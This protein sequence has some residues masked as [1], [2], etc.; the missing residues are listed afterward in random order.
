MPRLPAS[1][2]LGSLFLVSLF[3]CTSGDDA[4]TN[5]DDIKKRVNPS[6]GTAAFELKKPSWYTDDFQSVFQFH[7]V[8]A[9]YGRRYERAGGEFPLRSG[10]LYAPGYYGFGMS[11]GSMSMNV[12][13]EIGFISIY[14]PAGIVLKYERP[15]TAG[16]NQIVGKRAGSG[17]DA[18]RMV[19]NE[20][21]SRPQG[22]SVAML[23]GRYEIET[24]ANEKTTYDI[25]E[26][27]KKDILL[28][29]ASVQLK[30]EAIDAEFPGTTTCLSIDARGDNRTI[31]VTRTSLP[32][33][34]EKAALVIPAGSAASVDIRACGVSSNVPMPAGA[35]HA[36][37]VHR[38]EVNDL[39]IVDPDG[40][41]R[42]VRGTFVVD[43]K[44]ADGTYTRIIGSERTHTGVDLTDGTYRVTSTATNV[45]PHVVDVSFP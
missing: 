33:A 8:T 18:I 45:P 35:V 26:G 40:A 12:P 4:G 3:A 5:E 41:H 6:S 37:T 36:I 19:A 2:V 21:W 22:Y 28:P 25:A 39:D 31:G 32:I 11:A 13:L 30:F 10:I 43:R 34:R 24:S 29:T 1:H 17:Q 14:E 44:N 16:E 15:I 20:L 42:V 9:E 38:L 27:E 7:D 23:D